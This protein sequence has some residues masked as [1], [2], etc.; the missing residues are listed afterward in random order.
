M[1][2]A[3]PGAGSQPGPMPAAAPASLCLHGSAGGPEGESK[4]EP[5][6]SSSLPPSLP[7][8]F[9]VFFPFPP[10]SLSPALFSFTF[11][12]PFRFP[13]P[14]SPPPQANALRAPRFSLA[15]AKSQRSQP[16]YCGGSLCR[17][18]SRAAPSGRVTQSRLPS[19]ASRRLPHVS[20]DGDATTS[21]GN[22][23][24]CS[25]PLPGKKGFGDGEAEPP[26]FQ[27]VPVASCP[28]TGHLCK[29]PGSLFLMPSLQT[30]VHI[31]K[32]R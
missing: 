10:P 12:F 5:S 26:V 32:T 3:A 25:L 27:L 31:D 11:P 1:S 17:A 14:F 18:S 15:A 20:K 28:A 7:L 6:P 16:H 29:E 30:C 19:T 13:F 4:G 2:A 23:C 9:L 8:L 21:R 24:Q 22:P